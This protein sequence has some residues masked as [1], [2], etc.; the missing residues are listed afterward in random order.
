VD[1]DEA[2]LVALRSVNLYRGRGYDALLPLIDEPEVFEAAG[3]SGKTYSVEVQAF[4]DDR[5]HADLRVVAA[6]DDGSLR[7]SLRP[8]CEDFIMR[9]D[10]SF[11]GEGG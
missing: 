11:V 4:W 9:P 8:L 3:P 5:P 1:D 7:A 2:R 10:G 6:V